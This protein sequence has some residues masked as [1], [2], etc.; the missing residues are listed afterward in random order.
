MASKNEFGVSLRQMIE[1]RDDIGNTAL[2][3][4]VRNLDINLAKIL[5]QEGVDI[6]AI[7]EDGD[8]P[9]TEFALRSSDSNSQQSFELLSFLIE[10]GA[11]INYRN[12]EGYSSLHHAVERDNLDVVRFL[13]NHGANIN[14]LNNMG[15]TPLHLATFD[16][17][18]EIVEFLLNHYPDITKNRENQTPLDIAEDCDDGDIVKMLEDY[19]EYNIEDIKEPEM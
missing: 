12:N 8:T 13:L 7:N 9:L 19:I 3:H 2:H 17:N 18:I 10:H 11:N 1:Q 14:I 15:D 16:C 5:I 6:N 4:A